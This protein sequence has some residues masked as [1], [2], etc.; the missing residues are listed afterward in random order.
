MC[1][2]KNF[3]GGVRP[4][5]TTQCTHEA[6]TFQSSY[7]HTLP[8]SGTNSLITACSGDLQLRF[9]VS[10]MLVL[11]HSTWFRTTSIW[12]PHLPT[13]GYDESLLVCNS[14]V[15]SVASHWFGAFENSAHLE[16]PVT[17]A[18]LGAMMF[19]AVI[20]G[21]ISRLVN[22]LDETATICH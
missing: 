9:G 2:S 20:S 10:K 3:K 19:T 11:H 5:T 15:S 18:W 14:S 16:S 1:L 12:Y 17:T 21:E 22:I 7:V 13:S 4:G 6:K 8:L